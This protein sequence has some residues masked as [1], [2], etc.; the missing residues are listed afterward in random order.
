MPIECS[1]EGQ[2]VRVRADSVADAKLCIKQ[3]KLK[4][5]EL[6]AQKREVT[7]RIAQIRAE[8]L[9]TKVGSGLA[10]RG[11][12][13]MAGASRVIKNVTAINVDTAV[14]EQ[15][16]QKAALE[17]NIAQLDKALLQL[18]RYILEAAE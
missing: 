10:P 13:F 15:Q 17:D 8:H 12:G 5:Q 2:V 6:Q 14:R 16:S 7:A 3:I 11:K 9:S 1:P 4:K 18:E